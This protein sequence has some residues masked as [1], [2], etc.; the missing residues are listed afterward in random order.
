MASFLRYG[1]SSNRD[2]RERIKKGEQ[3]WPPPVLFAPLSTKAVGKT[4]SFETDSDNEKDKTSYV[5]IEI[6][7]DPDDEESE[8]Y[9]EK[10]KKYATGTPEEWMTYLIHMSDLFDKLHITNDPE[11][12]HR[13]YQTTM[14]T[15]TKES[16]NRVFNARRAANKML[17]SNQREK[18]NVVLA[19]VINELTQQVFPT[20][21][22][23]HREQ[24]HYMRSS[25]YLG[26]CEPKRFLERLTHMN[27]YF[28]YFPVGPD[29]EPH[30]KYSEYELI[31]MADTAKKQSWHK[32]MMQHGKRPDSFGTLAEV[33]EYY[34]QLYN[35]DKLTSLQESR[36]P[37][38]QTSKSDKKRKGKPAKSM[39]TGRASAKRSDK[40]CENCGK[41]GHKS[42]DCWSLD[43]N[44]DKRPQKSSRNNDKSRGY[45]KT[46][47][48]N[49]IAKVCKSIRKQELKDAKNKRAKKRHVRDSDDDNSE[50]ED[51]F[52]A[53]V[54][55]K[56]LICEVN[57]D[58]NDDYSD[59]S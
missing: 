40:N 10:I 23:A 45:S 14:T 18:T 3:Q 49:L 46:E 56:N 28:P 42:Y 31:G 13:R 38:S 41:F 16:Y 43:K 35:A 26:N 55:C 15:P 19:A 9:D 36:T 30:K 21:Q 39:N 6:R 8:T 50:H 2:I 24:S 52:A 11:S 58:S 32:I 22:S 7:F 51:N 4:S 37:T 5:T 33:Q 59:S 17:A 34:T 53:S 20:W 12:Q 47:Q 27:E 29:E 1:T 57:S 44:K 54:G 48:V 25:L